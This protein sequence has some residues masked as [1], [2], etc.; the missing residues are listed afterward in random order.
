MRKNL[1]S[2]LLCIMVMLIGL[3]AML[4]AQTVIST[5]GLISDNGSTITFLNN[6]DRVSHADNGEKTYSMP[7]ITG[8][9]KWK[10]NTAITKVIFDESIKDWSPTTLKDFFSG[11]TNLKEIKGLKNLNTE[12]VTSLEGMFENCGSSTAP[13]ELDL[14]SINGS[15]ITNINNIFKG[16]HFRTINVSFLKN[17]NIENA[18][19]AF[20]DCSD[21]EVLNAGDFN[22]TSITTSD[23]FFSGTGTS[24]KPFELKASSSLNTLVFSKLSNNIYSWRDGY[25]TLAVAQ[26]PV[27]A[28]V[29]NNILEFHQDNDRA[30]YTSTY[31]LNTDNEIPGWITEHAS[32]ITSVDF[33]HFGNYS[34]TTIANWFKGT[35]ITSLPLNQLN[36]RQLK[37]INSLA[38][39]CTKLS[40]INIGGFSTPLLTD[41]L[42]AWEG[43]TAE[44][45]Y[46]GENYERF[47]NINADNTY[48]W[49]NGKLTITSFTTT[50]DMTFYIGTGSSSLNSTKDA[51]HPYPLSINVAND[52]SSITINSKQDSSFGEDLVLPSKIG[53]IAVT[54]ISCPLFSRNLNI[55][56]VTIPSTVKNIDIAKSNPFFLGCSNLQAINVASNN[57]AYKSIDGIVYSADGTKLV[58]YPG[59][60]ASATIPASVKSLGVNSLY[61]AGY[62][63]YNYPSNWDVDITFAG[64]SLPSFTSESV[65]GS[66]ANLHVKEI[67]NTTLN[68]FTSYN[69]NGRVSASIT[70]PQSG[71]ATFASPKIFS[72]SKNFTVYGI[73]S[74]EIEANRIKVEALNADNKDLKFAAS[75]TY[76]N[77]VIIKGTSNEA[78]E[79][80]YYFNPNDRAESTYSETWLKSTSGCNAAKLTSNNG[81]NNNY[82][83]YQG[84]FHPIVDGSTI[85]ANKAYLS[86]PYL[87]TS[88]AKSLI[89][90]W[91]DNETTNIESLD[92]TK[93]ANNENTT[94]YNLQGIKIKG[95]L[96]SVPAG[97]YIM[98]GK[99]IVVK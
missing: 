3:P 12:N 35:N 45:T 42:N 99:K 44:V 4:S 8:K 91:D 85:Q 22:F 36:V 27:Y 58:C 5:Y 29:V 68:L 96:N 79:V 88:A 82:V 93:T 47:G 72:V 66:F 41:S 94:L 98:N 54:K 11:L 86:I 77:G 10:G 2:K 62:D 19:N 70:M 53:N 28:A 84:A 13:L 17:S 40:T 48:S 56:T 90:N 15:K 76:G 81:V 32:D 75:T 23:G 74:D 59:R 16:S 46:I 9:P 14:S 69:Y 30:N 26:L 1:F 34:P 24:E 71:Y 20:A 57:S 67:S 64:N 31:D 51:A 6:A 38:A 97:I 78:G 87:S 25:F 65:N 50:G 80:T 49:L 21:L 92:E 60:K 52:Y 73:V 55:K 18:K 37:S 95:N 43:V 89:I 63:P 7:N 83:L 61:H 33:S 39:G